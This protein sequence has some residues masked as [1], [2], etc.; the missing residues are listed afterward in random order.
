MR[1]YTIIVREDVPDMDLK[2]GDVLVLG[3]PE[4]MVVQRTVFQNYG[5]VL[6]LLEAG[7]ADPLN[8]FRPLDDL[9]SAVGLPLP[10]RL[11]RPVPPSPRRR[12]RHLRR[13]K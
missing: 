8:P 6:N 7:L 4:G 11:R 12:S 9:A 1:P 5:R 13:L 2:A 3:R 10:P